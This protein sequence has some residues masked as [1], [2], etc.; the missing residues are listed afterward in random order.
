MTFPTPYT[1]QHEAAEVVAEDDLGNTSVIYS[2]PVAV[3]VI[4]IAPAV[5]EILGGT[6]DLHGST[7]YASRGVTDV[8]LYAPSEFAPGLQDRITLLDGN[9]YEVIGMD[10][11]SFGFQEW[12]AGNVVKLKRVTG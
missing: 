9:V 5:T 1:V 11:W 2:A 7:H 6:G 4:A 8:D 3:Q 12:S 10:T